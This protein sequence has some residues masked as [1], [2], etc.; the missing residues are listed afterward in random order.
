MPWGLLVTPQRR[1]SGAPS[2]ALT[3]T[4]NAYQQLRARILSGEFAPGTSLD[5]EALAAE[6]GL[7]TTP[8]RE[9]LRRLESERLVI[10]RAHRDTVVT[11]VSI[12][13][14]E[15]V[16]AIRLKL[17]PM[18]VGL[19]ARHADASDI[20]EMQRL[21]KEDLS[22]AS[23]AD[24]LYHNRDLHREIYRSCG[25]SVL[26][27]ILDSLWDLSDRYRMITLKDHTT[28]TSAAV[29]HAEIVSAI[30]ARDADEAAHLMRE[31]V[32]QSLGRIRT[33]S[34]VIGD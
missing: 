31:H 19:T 28:V 10:S 4:D 14:L 9:A 32:R 33:A 2:I 22:G 27:Q 25:N 21:L 15:E 8:V 18:A 26:V 20:A 3:K 6:L 7:S 17:D 13:L 23:A 29:E 30:V 5:Q 24:H 11:P 16:Y 12:T 1:R 34:A